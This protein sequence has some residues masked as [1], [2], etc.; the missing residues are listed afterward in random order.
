LLLEDNVKTISLNKFFG[1]KYPQID[2]FS[3]EIHHIHFSFLGN[4]FWAFGS[5]SATKIDGSLSLYR[6]IRLSFE[7]D[8][9]GLIDENQISVQLGIN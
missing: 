8:S 4:R 5:V 6:S 7:T 9:S 2:L 3:L 1:N